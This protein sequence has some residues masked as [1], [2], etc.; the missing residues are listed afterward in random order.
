MKCLF[1]N[2]WIE[3]P[4]KEKGKIVQKFCNEKCHDA[5]HN[6]KRRKYEQLASKFKE[7]NWQLLPEPGKEL[8]PSLEIY[9]NKLKV[10]DWNIL[11][12]MVVY[13]LVKDNIIQYIG[14]SGAFL[15]RLQQHAMEKEF[16]YAYVMV[17]PEDLAG[18]IESFLID[19]FNPSW[20][21]A[22]IT[23]WHK[24]EV[25]RFLGEND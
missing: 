7:I 11:S 20:N 4:R 19:K 15:F 16:D 1:C 5:Y 22:K 13:F 2:T 14:A 23:P 9:R 12:P 8:I 3:K 6:E 24:E 25:K 21:K 17:V 18:D 10:L